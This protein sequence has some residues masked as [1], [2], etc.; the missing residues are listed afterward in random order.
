MT[1]SIV[2]VIVPNPPVLQAEEGAQ[3]DRQG[4]AVASKRVFHC[5]H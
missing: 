5:E 2:P 1:T 4:R 3:T